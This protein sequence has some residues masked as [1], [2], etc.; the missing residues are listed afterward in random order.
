MEQQDDFES[1]LKGTANKF[2]NNPLSQQSVSQLIDKRLADGKRGLRRQFRNEVIIIILG[3]L[4]LAYFLYANITHKESHTKEMFD[5]LNLTFLGGIMYMFVSLCLFLGLIQISY[6]QRGTG[7]KGYIT[8][9]YTKTK[10]TLQFY[11][12]FSTI[13]TVIMVGV[14]FSVTDR[15]EWYWI[16]AGAALFGMFIHYANLAYIRRRFGKQVDEIKKLMDELVSS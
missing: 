1:L 13:V 14:L 15:F 10:Q 3:I 12:W 16:V 5:F 8:Y 11:L 9:V 2:L 6:I 4:A 7:I